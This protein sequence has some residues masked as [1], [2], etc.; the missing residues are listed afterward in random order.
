MTVAV[1]PL[2]LG[3]MTSARS[4]FLE[5]EPGMMRYPVPGFLCE[6]PDGLVVFDTG[7]HPDLATSTARLRL[8]ADLFEVEMGPGA[9]PHRPAR[10]ASASSRPTSTSRC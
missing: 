7:L 9:H 3:W 5:G 6:H 2:L 10:R 8:L 4:G 1:R